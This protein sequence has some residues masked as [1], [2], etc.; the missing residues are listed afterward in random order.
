MKREVRQTADHREIASHQALKKHLQCGITRYYEAR[1]L[2]RGT[3]ES[4]A[5]GADVKEPRV[6]C[7]TQVRN[8]ALGGSQEVVRYRDGLVGYRASVVIGGPGIGTHVTA[9]GLTGGASAAR[10]GAESGGALPRF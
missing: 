3:G 1:E 5:P 4:P 8:K 6:G 7:E 9:A 2:T 10:K